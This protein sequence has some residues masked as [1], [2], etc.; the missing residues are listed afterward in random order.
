MMPLSE[1][2]VIYQNFD[3]SFVI[4]EYKLISKLVLVNK[5][6][7]RNVFFKIWTNKKAK[8]DAAIRN[9]CDLLKIRCQFRNY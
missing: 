2:G 3:V 6:N 4:I 5:S 1:I 7:F 9:W 8:N